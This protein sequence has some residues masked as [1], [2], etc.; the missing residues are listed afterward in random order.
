[1]SISKINY[2]SA[3]TTPSHLFIDKKYHYNYNQLPFVRIYLC[4]NRL[5][6]FIIYLLLFIYYLR[7]KIVFDYFERFHESSVRVFRLVI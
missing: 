7:S 2:Q 4:T 6:L 1:M 3:F 5:S